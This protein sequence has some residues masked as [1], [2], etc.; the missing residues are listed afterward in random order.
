MQWLAWIRSQ[1]WLV[2]G[3]V[4]VGSKI[5]LEERKEGSRR[6]AGSVAGTDHR[7]APCA[8]PFT[9]SYLS[10][11]R[12]SS[13]SPS[14]RLTS[15]PSGQLHVVRWYLSGQPPRVTEYVPHSASA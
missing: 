2:S 7:N 4:L 14:S 5:W 11:S 9:I 15:I 3:T 13:A 10:A 12:A 6:T 1:A 8:K